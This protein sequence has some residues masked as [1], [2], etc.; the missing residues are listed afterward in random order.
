MVIY[1]NHPVQFNSLLFILK[2]DTY[3]LKPPKFN[4]WYIFLSQQ[5]LSQLIALQQIIGEDK[6]NDH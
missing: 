4:I 2:C 3:T 1:F 5:K 6:K